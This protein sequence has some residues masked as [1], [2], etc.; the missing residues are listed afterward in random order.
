M[1]RIMSVV[2]VFEK[3]NSHLLSMTICAKVICTYM[4]F[5]CRTAKYARSSYRGFELFSNAYMYELC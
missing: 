5:Q 3:Y 4:S 2:T 1:G